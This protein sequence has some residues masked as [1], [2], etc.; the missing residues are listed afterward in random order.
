MTATIKPRKVAPKEFRRWLKSALILLRRKQITWLAIACAGTLAG[1]LTDV[2][3]ICQVFTLLCLM[4]VTVDYA[5]V[6]DDHSPPTIKEFPQWSMQALRMAIPS[7]MYCLAVMITIFAITTIIQGSYQDASKVLYKETTLLQFS[8]TP[9]LYF[10]MVSISAAI[11]I[12]SINCIILMHSPLAHGIFS[13]LL[14]RKFG[15]DRKI[16]HAL[17]IEGIKKNLR[18]LVKVIAFL[19]AIA[20]IGASIAPLASLLA[21]FGFSATLFWVAFKDIFLHDATVKQVEQETD[22]LHQAMVE[23]TSDEIH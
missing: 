23:S 18:P 20:I 6:V 12:A 15:L 19:V 11:G 21:L 8:T 17:E 5:S 3:S 10:W 14:R 2:S 22:S 13:Y 9:S 7:A 4:M 1:A 16:A